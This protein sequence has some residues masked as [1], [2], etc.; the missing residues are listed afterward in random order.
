[1]PS[2]YE[3]L[4]QLEF[5]TRE[6]AIVGLFLTAGV[7]ILVRDWRVSLLSLLGQ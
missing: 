3:V 1:M 4:D 7:I 6:L 2:L 5:I